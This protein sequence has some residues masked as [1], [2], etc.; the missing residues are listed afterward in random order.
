M[1]LVNEEIYCDPKM[2]VGTVKVVLKTS[3]LEQLRESTTS[4]VRYYIAPHTR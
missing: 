3:L 4:S 1:R 2:L